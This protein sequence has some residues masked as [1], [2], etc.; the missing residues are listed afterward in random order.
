M[1]VTEH[2]TANPTVGENYL[3]FIRGLALDAIETSKDTGLSPEDA[4]ANIIECLHQDC[5]ENLADMLD[6]ALDAEEQN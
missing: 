6:D 4:L 3:R 2:T 1:N 5:A